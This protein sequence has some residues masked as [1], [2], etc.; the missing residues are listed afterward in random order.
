MALREERQESISMI[1]LSSVEPENSSKQELSAELAASAVAQSVE[2]P[3][4]RP[5]EEVHQN[6]RDFDSRSR[7]KVVG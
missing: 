5:L 1:I 2:R 4:L 3:E 7:P 6:R